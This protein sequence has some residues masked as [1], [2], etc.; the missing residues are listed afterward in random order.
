[1]TEAEL[2]DHLRATTGDN[3]SKWAREH[4]L[5]P[6]YVAETIS[7]RRAPGGKILEAIGFERC[8]DYQPIR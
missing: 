5:S 1:M 3:L 2:R 4:G 7:G 8:V 6:S